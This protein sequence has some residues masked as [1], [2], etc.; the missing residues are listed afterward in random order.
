MS[1][2]KRPLKPSQR[3]RIMHTCSEAPTTKARY[4]CLRNRDRAKKL[5]HGDGRV[6][7]T[8]NTFWSLYVCT[9]HIRIESKV[10]LKLTELKLLP[11]CCLL[12]N[13]SPFKEIPP[14]LPPCNKSS[15]L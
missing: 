12:R 7:F 3:Q 6:P 13:V 9:E 1:L 4:V 5:T 2:C 15:L 8:Q 11:A 14:F 10:I